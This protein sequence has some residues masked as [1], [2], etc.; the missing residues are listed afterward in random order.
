MA[1]VTVHGTLGSGARDVARIVA[2]RLRLDYVDHELIVSLSQRMGLSVEAVE[3]HDER[4]AGFAERLAAYFRAFLERSAAAGPT[5]PFLGPS[6]LE[7]LITR[8]YAEAAQPEDEFDQRA[9]VRAITDLIVGLA[10]GSNIIIV[11]RASQIVLRDFPGAAHALIVA[12]RSLRVER[13]AA[14]EGLAPDAAEKRVRQAE[15]D[16]D[17]FYR[18]LFKVNAADPCLY[19]VICNTGRLSYEAAA[20]A[21]IAAASSHQ[22][23]PG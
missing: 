12:P 23:R 22:P 19:D 5:D 21:T 17:L 4:A 1:V 18:R 11:G 6:G 2:E 3:E 15:Q 8:T 9:Y 10:G 16:R 14:A 13:V 20:E 7:P